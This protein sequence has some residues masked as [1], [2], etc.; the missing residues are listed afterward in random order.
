MEVDDEDLDEEA[1]AREWFE[2]EVTT[3][4]LKI[5]LETAISVCSDSSSTSQAKANAASSL[6]RAAGVFDRKDEGRRKKAIHE[7]SMEEMNRELERLKR[8]RTRR[9]PPDVFD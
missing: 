8:G 6:M 5:A 4:G 9:A 1:E 7:M 3:R 2:R